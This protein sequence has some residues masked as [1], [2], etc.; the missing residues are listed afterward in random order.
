MTTS[1]ASRRTST[2]PRTSEAW[3]RKRFERALAVR[4]ERHRIDT[5]PTGSRKRLASRSRARRLLSTGSHFGC[6]VHGCKRRSSRAGS[7]RHAGCFTCGPARWSCDVRLVHLVPGVRRAYVPRRASRY[8][9]P[10]VSGHP[11]ATLPAVASLLRLRS[12]AARV[13]RLWARYRTRRTPSTDRVRV[14]S[15]HHRV[16]SCATASTDRWPRSARCSGVVAATDGRRP[17]RRPA[18]GGRRPGSRCPRRS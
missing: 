5:A 1:S 2:A 8:G 18:D 15:R 12:R 14:A 10:T 11:G 6:A 16:A 17:P 3:V 13:R 7:T 4:S 9:V